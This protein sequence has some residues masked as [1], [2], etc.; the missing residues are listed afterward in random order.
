MSFPVSIPNILNYNIVKYNFVKCALVAL[1]L[2]I[3]S[4]LF[5]QSGNI[6]I[7]KVGNPTS[8]PAI[9]DLSDPSN[10]HLGLLL[11]TVTFTSSVDVTTIPSPKQ[12]LMVYNPTVSTS[13]GLSGAGFYYWSGSQWNY[14]SNSGNSGVS[15]ILGTSPVIISGTATNPII[16]LEGTTGALFEGTG[17]GSTTLAGSTK[18][19]L[20]Y[21]S[22]SNT[23][24][25]LTV[26]TNGQIISSNGTVPSWSSPS[27][28]GIINAVSP[29]APITASLAGGTLTIGIT[30]PIAVQYGG[31]GDVTFIPNTILIGNG[32]GIINTTAAIANGVLISGGTGIPA[33]LAIGSNGQVLTMG[34]TAPA[35]S[36]PS[37]L[38]TVNNGLT[39]NSG[40]IQHGGA[41]TKSTVIN[42]SSG[43]HTMAYD[44]GTGIPTGTG[45]GTFSINNGGTTN[46]A[47]TVK[48]YGKSRLVSGTSMPYGQVGIDTTAPAASA[49]LDINS[50]A[51]GLL[52][53]RMTTTQQNALTSIA[54]TGLTIYNTTTN[55]FMFYSGSSWQ[56][57]TCI[58]SGTPPGAPEFL[59]TPPT[60]VCKNTAYTYSVSS[61]SG[62]S[63][64]SWKISPGTPGN[65]SIVG[66]NT[67]VAIVTTP[68]LTGTYTI[69]CNDSN[70][71]GA[72]PYS[73]Q[74]ITVVTPPATPG[75][76]IGITPL[77]QGVSVQTFSVTA[78]GTYNWV[79]PSEYSGS[80]TNNSININVSPLATGNQVISVF[81]LNGSCQSVAASSFT[82]VI[83]PTPSTPTGLTGPSAICGSS[84]GNIYTVN[85]AAGNTYVWSAPVGFVVT[86][87]T[88]NTI[89]YSTTPSAVSGIISV[90]ANNGTC[91]SLSPATF[92]VTVS[93]VLA[94][95]SGVNPA[96]CSSSTNGS[97]TSAPSGGT[98]PYTYSWSTGATTSSITSLA[99]GT[100][101]ITVHDNSGC[102][103]TG[104]VT[105]VGATN[106][107]ANASLISNVSCFGGN[108]SAATAP[109]GGTLPYTYTWSPGGNTNGSPSLTANTYTVTVQ[110]HSGCSGTGVVT[111]TQ[112]AAALAANVTFTNVAC[113][114]GNGTVQSAPTGG[115][116]P[117]TYSWSTGATTTSITVTANTYTVTVTDNHSCTSTASVTVTQP[118][119]ALGITIAST[120]SITCVGGTGTITANAATGGTAPYTY[121]WTATGGTNLTTTAIPAGTYTITATDNHGCTATASSTLA[122]GTGSPPTS[123]AITGALGVCPAASVTYTATPTGGTTPYTYSWSI[124]AALGT[125]SGSSTNSTMTIT[126]AALANNSAPVT[127]TMTCT[128]SNPCGT[129]IATYTVVLYPLHFAAPGFTYAFTGGYQQ[130][131]VPSCITSV[132]IT[133]KG[134]QGGSKSATK[135]GGNG[136]TMKGTFA[137]S[138][139]QVLTMLVGQY[140]GLVGSFTYAGGGGGTYVALGVNF[141]TA[142]PM[143]VSGGGGGGFNAAGGTAAP[144]TTSGTGTNPGTGGNGAPAVDCDGG[145]GGFF[146]SGANDIFNSQAGGA[147]FQEGGAG[148]A[149]GGQ[150]QPGGFGGG[151]AADFI[152]TCNTESGAG[153][154][155]SG[156]SGY[157]NGSTNPNGQAGGS[158][159][160][161]TSQTNTAGSNAGNGSVLIAW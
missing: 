14:I 107:V 153:G 145:G 15:S 84:T 93:S 66:A 160:G 86:G 38:G 72:S 136:A 73:Q 92:S 45:T 116:T 68:T 16:N 77:C 159:N 125:I 62:A 2:G 85:F 105:L 6:S 113:R 158:F 104:T 69:E 32:T 1:C 148:G 88:A 50:T 42:A 67:T 112:P 114:G 60:T 29:T 81:A 59:G 80:S 147:G 82:T 12:G 120:S 70:S 36:S 110:D 48:H 53:P 141:A 103:S 23:P 83:N 140:P 49:V 64:Y 134:G 157:N 142:T 87:S 11:P 52:I 126:T 37:F 75:S 34:A 155:Y 133:T 151:G 61:V 135:L 4:T 152:G 91:Q 7:N 89:T 127:G 121:A 17:A 94:N 144:T 3:S 99:G 21:N 115:T 58:C 35:W 55:C 44:L 132:T 130:F 33:W 65:G 39:N 128:V 108:G 154:G 123:A 54:A 18:G 156:G 100:Y 28:L 30:T 109:T 43:N 74:V 9:L 101:T 138:S 20:L 13:N 117:Y 79:L 90:Y 31:T 124:S 95:V 41:L 5:S 143:I 40:T 102:S 78:A 146:T 56:S 118:A 119:S 24:A 47:I 131:Y 150:Y 111:I 51:G 26:G 139:G 129:T 96:P 106:I 76:I 57:I 10:S 22:S 161:G 98:T 97:A 137:V 122:P 71:C 46:A 8:N 63:S 27:T 25:W 149:P 19:S